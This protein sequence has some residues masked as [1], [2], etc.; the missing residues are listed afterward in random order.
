MLTQACVVTVMR[1][2]SMYAKCIGENA[3]LAGCQ[4]VVYDNTQE[5]LPIPVRYN[6]FLDTRP[7]GWIVFCH[8]DW[9]I[10]EP[11]L[12][13]LGR[14]DPECIYGPIGI[15]LQEQPFC[16]RL[17]VRGCVRQ[18]DKDGTGEC[19]IRGVEPEGRVDTLDCQ[20]LIIHASLAERY[21]LRFDPQ[22]AFDMYVEDFCVAA[23]ER[24]GILTRA[25]PIDCIHRSHGKVSGSFRPALRQARRKYAASARRYATIVG[26]NSIFGRRAC[27]PIRKIKK[28]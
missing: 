22:F 25:C 5:N 24:H 10:L 11:L 17:L 2:S 27:K 9:Q 13:L 8:E 19:V 21:G 18:S 14:L 16:D 15:C 12:P 7:E 1:D 6:A 23:F 3:F 20:C 4:Q 28:K 26:H